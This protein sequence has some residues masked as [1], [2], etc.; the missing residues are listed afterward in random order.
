MHVLAA[1]DERVPV[2]HHDID[3]VYPRRVK[4][5]RLITESR[6]ARLQAEGLAVHE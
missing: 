4:K 1:L 5:P 2:V 6:R 3:R